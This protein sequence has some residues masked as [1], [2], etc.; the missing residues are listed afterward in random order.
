M[1]AS[2]ASAAR[3]CRTVVAE[4]GRR[5][6][7]RRSVG[8]RPPGSSSV[9]EPVAGVASNR[10]GERS[11]STAATSAARSSKDPSAASPLRRRGGGRGWRLRSRPR[12]RRERR[13][14]PIRSPRTTPAG[15]HRPRGVR[16][17]APRGR[18][19]AMAAAAPRTRSAVDD[20][21]RRGARTGGAGSAAERSVGVAS[22]KASSAAAMPASR[23]TGSAGRY[24]ARARRGPA[25]APRP[26]PGATGRPRCGPP[27]R[28]SWRRR[29]GR[30]RAR[31]GRGRSS[32]GSGFVALGRTTGVGGLVPGI[33]Q[34][35]QL[36]A[37]AGDARA[38]GPGRDAED[39]A[40]SRR[41]RSRTGPGARRGPGTPRRPD[42][43][44]HRWPSG[45]GAPRCRSPCA[46]PDPGG[47][48]DRCRRGDRRPDAACG[49]G[50][51]PGRRWSPPDRPRWR[52][53]TV[54]R[55]DGCPWR[56]R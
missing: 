29:G 49:A 48:R 1:T 18:A 16:G 31:R 54:R 20:G 33:E 5:C 40:R 38:D 47:P 12:P 7:A 45:R 14:W 3:A 41:S 21:P 51:R 42:R 34:L 44:R 50:A 13:R 36:R 15:H 23:A 35:R 6:P 10:S 2:P 27:P 30:R 43:G 55:T 28:A 56:W 9:G 37:T 39:H 25:G 24:L 53:P 4:V 11:A 19:A 52:T 46:R 32:F 8:D 17:R 22:A 26:G